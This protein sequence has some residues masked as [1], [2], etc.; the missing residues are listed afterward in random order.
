MIRGSGGVVGAMP[1]RRRSAP[2][3]ITRYLRQLRPVLTAPRLARRE[4]IRRVG[5]LIEE[6]RTGEPI[7]LAHQAGRYGRDAIAVFRDARRRLGELTPPPE[8]QALHGAI[9]Q[10]IELHVQACEELIRTDEQR[11]PR[12]LRDVQERLAA[13]RAWAQRFNDEY[14]RL[15]AELRGHVAGQAG[16]ERDQATGRGTTRR[17]SRLRSL[18]G[19]RE[20]GG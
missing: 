20:G 14:T 16:R 6:S 15:A 10:W 4:W 1:E 2:H 19:Q 11:A 9:E 18:F 5:R 7:A 17:L 3:E 12:R 8:C 13:G